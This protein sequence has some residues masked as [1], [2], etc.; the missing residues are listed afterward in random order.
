MVNFDK[1]GPEKI[2]EVYD[3]KIRMHGF[4]VI[5]NTSL[6]IGKGGIRMTSNVTVE[7][8]ASLART[9]T[10]KNALVE[11]PFGGAKA[12]I[13]LDKNHSLKQKEELIRSFANAIKEYVPNI[14]I[15]GPDMNTTEHE[16][17]IFSKTLKNKNACTGKPEKLNGL[18]H[19]LGST[20]FGVCHATLVALK[21]LNKNPSHMTF[22]V[23]GFGNVG[24]FASK[25]L[26]ENG[27]K[28]VAVS[29][30]KGVL[31]EKDGINFEKLKKIKEKTGSVVN[32]GN[33]TNKKIFE[34]DGDILITAA[35]PNLIK[36]EDVNKVRNK[37]IVEG[38]NIP[39]TPEVEEL[40]YKKKILVIPDFVANAGGVISSY[41]EYIGGNKEKMFKLVREKITKNTELI[42]NESLKRKTKLRDVALEIAK[43]R[44][45]HE[46]K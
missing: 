39:M 35:I 18:P 23:E 8:I 6:G 16:M 29:D 37:I 26:I 31:Y 22:A 38:S 42:L 30:S 43:K 2:L 36:K 9:M 25:F 24:F 10:W 19:E 7:E 40:L 20:G 5:D 46:S 3:N 34:V 32:Y 11:L 41:V 27:L 28:L 17:E 1:F 15:A 13:I 12:G 45:E 14:Y 33:K 21:H 44:I 4:L